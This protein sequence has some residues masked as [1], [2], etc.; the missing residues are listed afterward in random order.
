MKI[1]ALE[2]EVP[3][4]SADRFSEPLLQAEAARVWEMQQDGLIR[5]LY[6]R[7]DRRQAVLVLECE[8]AEEARRRLG[9]LPLAREGLIDFEVIPLIAYSGFA[10][11]FDGAGPVPGARDSD[12]PG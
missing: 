10:R 2:S 5:E 8:S 4:V 11:L 12:R 6:F 3:G 1:L 9:R 7:A